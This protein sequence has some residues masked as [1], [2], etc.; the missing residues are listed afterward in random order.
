MMQRALAAVF[1]S[2]L[3]R[4]APLLD[5]LGQRALDAVVITNTDEFYQLVAT[6]QV[7]AVIVDNDLRGFLCGV[8]LLERLF[9]DLVRPVSFLLAHENPTLIQRAEAIG[10]T[11]IVPVDVSGEELAEMVRNSV[12]TT[13]ETRVLI[14]PDARRLVQQIDCVRPLPQLLIRL[15]EYLR[16]PTATPADLARDISVDPKITAD[17]LRVTNSSHWGRAHK[18]TNLFEAVSFLGIHRTV[19]L[20]ISSEALHAQAPMLRKLPHALRSWYHCR[21]VLIGSTASAFASRLTEIAPETAYVLG[22]LQD[23]GILVLA[24]AHGERYEHLLRRS[25]EIAQVKLEVLERQDF[26]LTHAEVS[27]AVLQRWELPPSL[28][29]LVLHH[30]DPEHQSTGSG[31]DQAYLH[32]MQIGEAFANL[33]DSATPQRRHAL[34]GLLAHYGGGSARMPAR[35]RWPMRWRAPANQAISLASPPRL[36][37]RCNACWNNSID[38]NHSPSTLR[39]I[40]M[41]RHGTPPGLALWPWVRKKQRGPKNLTSRLRWQLGAMHLPVRPW[42]W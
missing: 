27:A 41:P 25:R 12:A 9:N 6:R 37:R 26:R 36:R 16:N 20:V 3:D 28:T 18:A 2:K 22:L 1:L 35:Q 17:L 13:R 29:N 4:V 23:V 19:S 30:H 14:P 21:N 8:E 5:A 39:L 11:R 40:R 10:V 42:C 38:R 31:I 24:S 33:I 32:V 7:D 15:C 34:N